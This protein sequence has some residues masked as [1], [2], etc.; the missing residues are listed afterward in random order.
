MGIYHAPKTV[1]MLAEFGRFWC[2]VWQFVI[3]G[4]IVPR[5]G[6]RAAARSRILTQ[7]YEIGNRSVPVVMI[8]GAFVG[9]TLAVQSYSQFKGIGLEDRLGSLINISVVKEL[10]PVLAAIMLAG[11][12]G[13]ALT[14]ELGT[15]H[16]TD[17]IDAL[18]S[19]GVDPIKQLVLPRVFACVLLTPFL[20]I[21]ADLMGVLGGYVMGVWYFGINSEA[22]W[23]FSADVVEKWDLLVGISKGIFFG[24]AISLI[25]C[26]KGFYCGRGAQGVGRACTEAFVYSFLSILILDF[27]LAVFFKAIYDT[28]WGTRIIF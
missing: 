19:M 13:G 2:F 17:Q 15:M 16:V 10:G 12:V 25:G 9:A 20:T 4:L 23:R 11:R 1:A 8:T 27:G 14:A 24:A 26:F 7:M 3:R 21:Y 22:F 28:F 18:R 5:Q 6:R